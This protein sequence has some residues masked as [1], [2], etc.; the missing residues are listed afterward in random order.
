MHQANRPHQL[1]CPGAIVGQG[2]RQRLQLGVERDHLLLL[3]LGS[4]DGIL[5]RLVHAR[6]RD[7]KEKVR[8]EVTLMG[9]SISGRGYFDR[10]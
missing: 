6:L 8:G 2:L 9:G 3:G 5:Q 10:V 4:G 7:A 1:L